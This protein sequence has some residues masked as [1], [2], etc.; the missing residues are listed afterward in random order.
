MGANVSRL[1]RP[2]ARDVVAVAER[3]L[4]EL[5]TW[6]EREDYAGWDP[7]DGLTSAVFQAT[8]LAAIAPARL[9]WIQLFKRSP[10]N[11]R[12][13]ARVPKLRN[14]KALGLALTAFSG[15]ATRGNAAALRARGEQLVAWLRAHRSA[16]SVA[17]GYPF[18]WQNRHFYAPAGLP[19]A[20]CSAFVVRGLMDFHAT[21]G[22]EQ[23]GELARASLPFFLKDLRAAPQPDGTVC[24]SYTPGDVTRVHNVNLL[25]A[26][27]IAELGKGD[28]NDEALSLADRARAFSVARQRDDGAWAYGEA[29]NQQWIDGF[30]TGFNLGALRRLEA[31]IPDS[32]GA[33]A[34]R[35][36]YEYFARH[37]LD[38]DGS[39]RHY[40]TSTY[41]WDTHNSAQAIITI[42]ESR[43]LDAQ[44]LDRAHRAYAVSRSMLY[45]G[46]GV[47]AYQRTRRYTNVIVYARWSQAWMFRALAEL[48][49]AMPRA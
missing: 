17:W 10:V 8:P 13:I 44:A 3:D 7:F 49:A 18:P 25:V 35:R 38:D 42:L 29:P 45:R 22:D 37:L 47:W 28:G 11:L 43:D 16:N 23:A 14:P 6:L 48:N 34:R 41:P 12:R 4:A 24:F 1:G 36:G 5:H 32:Q 30:H 31:V 39:P 20:V 15:L 46:D 19:N 21:F 9:A 27:T 2:E 40:A 26:A 33:S